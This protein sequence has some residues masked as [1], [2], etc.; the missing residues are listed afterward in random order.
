MS[1]VLSIVLNQNKKIIK[2]IIIKKRPARIIKHALTY[3]Y[4][5]IYLFINNKSS[6]YFYLR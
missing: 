5:Y 2:P 6:H 4:M 3:M 1:F